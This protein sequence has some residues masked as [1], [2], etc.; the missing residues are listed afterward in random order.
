MS[1]DAGIGQQDGDACLMAVVMIYV[2]IA[3]AIIVIKIMM[4][5][6]PEKK[7]LWKER[8]GCSGKH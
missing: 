2:A 3:F 7:Q 1:L 8:L 5:M 6:A 4:N